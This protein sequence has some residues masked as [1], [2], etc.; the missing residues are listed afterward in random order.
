MSR[1]TGKGIAVMVTAIVVVAAGVIGIVVVT[2]GSNTT[3]ASPPKLPVCQSSE[4]VVSLG[5]NM[6]L[7]SQYPEANQLIP[8]F[9][10]N[11]GLACNFR[12]GGPGVVAGIGSHDRP[13]SSLYYSFGTIMPRPFKLVSISRGGEDEALFEV[14]KN[15]N[16]GSGS[17]KGCILKTATWLSIS[18]YALPVQSVRYFT[19]QSFKIC[20]S[21]PGAR[22]QLNTGITW[23]SA[24][25]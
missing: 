10:K 24:S 14:Y 2:S 3:L 22:Q 21:D 12:E 17:A 18:G 6:K 1:V 8:V 19:R 4:I 20:F 25:R 9:F 5:P 13:A 7:S 11:H 23:L 16:S 15:P